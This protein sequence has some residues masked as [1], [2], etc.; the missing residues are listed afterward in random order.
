MLYRPLLLT[1][2]AVA[3]LKGQMALVPAPATLT[4]RGAEVPLRLSPPSYS[5]RLSVVIA[6]DTLQP[7]DLDALRPYLRQLY[8]A[9]KD[10][11]LFDLILFTSGGFQP[12]GPY[13]S[14]AALDRD[15]KEKLKQPEEP[16]PAIEPL[17]FYSELPRALISE[18]DQGWL[19]VVFAGRWPGLPEPMLDYTRAWFGRVFA[20]RRLR[21]IFWAP[22]DHQTLPLFDSISRQF[23]ASLD[24]PPPDAQEAAWTAPSLSDGFLL[25]PTLLKD[26]GGQSLCEWPEFIQNPEFSLPSLEDYS[27]LRQAVAARAALPEL[28]AVLA[29]N[30]R[31]ASGINLAADEALQLRDFTA[32]ARWLAAVVELEPASADRWRQYA[33]ALYDGGSRLAAEPVLQR[34]RQLNPRDP[35][36]AERAGRLRLLRQDV[37]GALALF[38]ESLTLQPANE[39]L[40]YVSAD[41]GR[42]TK[43]TARETRSLEKALALNGSRL[44]RRTRLVGLLLNAG[45]AARARPLVEEAAKSLPPEVPVL[46]DYAA[47]WEKLGEPARSLE[48]WLKTFALDPA[49]EQGYFESTRLLMAAARDADGL[50]VSEAGLLK[51]PGSARLH[52]AR[53]EMLER[54]GRP[55]D[56]RRALETAAAQLTDLEVQRRRAAQEDLYGKSAALAYRT[57]VESL[58]RAKAPPGE[59]QAATQRGLTVALRD[60]ETELAAWFQQRGKASPAAGT[61]GAPVSSSLAAP[62]GLVPG[63][64]D[65]MAFAAHMKKRASS[66]ATFFQEYSRTLADGLGVSEKSAADAYRDEVLTYFT[67]VQQLQAFGRIKDGRYVIALST[68]DN[69]AR[70]AAE[71]VVES[72]GYKL[73]VNKSKISLDAGEKKDQARKQELLSAL[74]LDPVEMV[75]VIEA[76]KDYNLEVEVGWANV[77]FGQAAWMREFAPKGPPGGGFSELLVREPTVAR[78]YAGLASAEPRAAELL[79]KRI[80]LRVLASE[81]YADLL[82]AFGPA[83]ALNGQ[84]E[85]IVPGGAAARPVWRALAQSDPSD[86]VAFYTK[87]LHQDNGRLLAFFSNLT[88]LDPLRQTFFTRNPQRAAAYYALFKDS[89]EMKPGAAKRTREASFLEF[90]REIPL[91]KDGTVDWP[92]SAEVWTVAR[93]ASTLEKT[94]RMMR[95]VDKAVAPASE[96]EVLIKLARRRYEAGEQK[97]SQVDNFLAVARIDA[98]RSTPLT[99]AEALLLAQSLSDCEGAYPYFAS[100]TE[101]HEKDLTRFLRLAARVKELRDVDANQLLAHFYAVAELID[102]LARHGSLTI[103]EASTLFSELCE[104]LGN[105]ATT[106]L[107]SEASAAVLESAQRQ[108]KARADTPDSATWWLDA[109]AGPAQLGRR[110]EIRKV[111]QAQK[112]PDLAQLLEMVR[113]ARELPRKPLESALALEKGFATLPRVEF[114]KNQKPRGEIRQTIELYNALGGPKILVEVKKQAAKKKPNPKEF[115]KLSR[116]LLEELAAPLA[117]AVLSL[118]YAYFLRTSDLA[119]AEDVLL[120]R[121]HQFIEL[122]STTKKTTWFPPAEFEINSDTIGSFARGSLAGFAYTAGRI[123]RAGRS[124]ASVSSESVQVMQTAAVRATP[125]WQLRVAD[126]R[127]FKLRVL[128]AREWVVESSRSGRVRESL[129]AASVGLIAPNRRSRLLA[130]LAAGEVA[131]AWEVLSLSDLYWLGDR[132]PASYP[133]DDPWPSPMWPAL[134]RASATPNRHSLLGSVPLF[135]HG[136]ST[137]SFEPLPPYEDYA[138]YLLPDRFSERV[139]EFKLS[140][141]WLADHEGIDPLRLA[142]DAEALMDKAF[143]SLQMIDYND[144]ASALKAWS[145]LSPAWLLEKQ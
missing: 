128:A 124:N 5:P 102:L 41:L 52:L 135:I 130:S 82:F 68:K 136:Y 26:A 137:P 27:R 113:H 38:D 14:V 94:Q 36:L 66:P 13:R 25:A 114:S 93:G 49:F 87:L 15:L 110:D 71:R 18:P 115:D 72:L 92:G 107:W 78:L 40:W 1:L 108:V 42:E 121:K 144:W 43:D 45:D 90:L 60:H 30:P 89:P 69:N 120:V 100:L 122:D 91:A 74:G 83:F 11:S 63:G 53:V 112:A 77:L 118:D 141:A 70:K 127:S 145:G 101:L 104:K 98:R 84:G 37:P 139:S 64:L 47:Y 39:D 24:A 57:L 116:Q 140:L 35:L 111:L 134:R 16:P 99:E 4:M 58:D 7:A 138:R 103:A 12:L 119:A 44:D 46:A 105:S 48:L 76:G 56:S 32:A 20:A 126:L 96:D 22:Q 81:K 132:L 97:V 95:K 79:A 142:A 6:V 51:A 86:A 10:K 73:K 54:L 67:K 109:L 8:G 65:G 33:H 131:P 62:D 55:Y 61:A 23:L 21:P 9:R 31:D 28:T 19:T 143:T 106:D 75:E 50:P 129:E 85:V 29:I 3:I 133:K 123:A 88:Q 125:L 80:G 59:L 17:R 34:A 117:L 2:C